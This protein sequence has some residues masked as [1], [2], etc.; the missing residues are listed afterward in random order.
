VPTPKAFSLLFALRHFGVAELTFAR[1][2]R[3]LG[4]QAQADGAAAKLGAAAFMEH[5]EQVTRDLV[6]ASR[7]ATIPDEAFATVP[8]PCPKCGGVV[9]ENY[10]KFQCQKCDFS[11][12]KVTA[13]AASGRPRKWP[14]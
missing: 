9:Q 1:A 3:R 2:D 6:L 7:M 10:R 8:A 5:I 11:I 14:S 4:V 12:W 13:R